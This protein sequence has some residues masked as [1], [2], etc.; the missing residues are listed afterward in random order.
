[1]IITLSRPVNYRDSE[2]SQ[3]ELDF[4]ALTGNDLIQAEENLKRSKPDASLWGTQHTAYI[5]AK[6]SHIPAE[7]ILSLPA[8]D[9]MNVYTSTINF[10]SN[11]DSQASQQEVTD[12]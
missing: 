12:A 7:I 6:A 10:F 2:I 11:T 1:M 8:K 4:E 9:F 5:A 3:L